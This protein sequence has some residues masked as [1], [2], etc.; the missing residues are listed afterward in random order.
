MIYV[1][2]LLGVGH[3]QRSGILATALAQRGLRVALVS[4]GMPIPHMT[5]TDYM[6]HQLAPVCSADASFSRLLDAEGNEIDNA[7][8]E[9]RCQQLLDLFERLQPQL[10]ITETFPFGRRM[11]SFELLPLLQ[12]AHARRNPPLV[13]ASIRDILQPKSKPGRNREICELIDKYYDHVLIHGDPSIATLADSF[14]E[15]ERIGDRLF[16]SGYICRPATTKPAGNTDAAEVLVSAG[17]SGTGLKILETALAARPMSRLSRRNWRILVSPAIDA[18]AFARLKRLADDSVIVERNRPD[19]SRMMQYASLSI[20]QAGY[21]TVTDILASRAASVLV[22]FDES[23][24]IEQS[25]RAR[26]LQQ[27]GRAAVL[28]ASRLNP[29]NLVEAI[30]QALTLDTSIKVNLDGAAN[31][32]AQIDAW[33]QAATV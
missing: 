21:N 2:H 18:T 11:M 31:S 6:L 29:A 14:A 9:A 25:L 12:R 33:L 30:D 16:Y 5:A 3:L 24:E 20:S 32:A 23:G 19:F 13:V 10:L 7:W 27:R 8:R 4:G 15:A 22:P 28:E 26:C 1:Q 17:G